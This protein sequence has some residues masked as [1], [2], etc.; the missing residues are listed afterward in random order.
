M[1]KIIRLRTKT[2]IKLSHEDD[3]TIDFI[4]ST[5]AK[6][7]DGD[8]IDPKGWILTNFLKNPVVLFGHDNR[9]LP[10]GKAENIR[11]E[12]GALKASVKFA[13]AEMNPLA[14]SVFQMVKGGFLNATS[15]G[16]SPV[17]FE[18]NDGGIKFIKQELLEFS[19]VP[20]PSNPEAL[21]TAKGLDL[22]PVKDWFKGYLDDWEKTKDCA[23]VS[24]SQMNNACD[25]IRKAINT[26]KK[27]TITF[28][29]A[30]PDGTPIAPE[31]EAWDG[32]A[33][34][35]AA[36]VDD[37]KIMATFVEQTDEELKK[38]DFKLPHH[39]EKGS[40]AVVFRGV[41]AAM[42]ALLGSSGGVDI[43]DSDRR[44]VYNHLAKHYREFDKEPPEFKAVEDQTLKDSALMLDGDGKIKNVLELLTGQLKSSL[45]ETAELRKAVTEQ[46]AQIEELT[47]DIT[48]NRL[49]HGEKLIR[50]IPDKATA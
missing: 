2:E 41:V 17:E 15:V 10:V 33:Q 1:P 44:G 31:G 28:D 14:E 8:T 7:R 25:I 21:V 9:S 24:K 6:D 26:E 27:D 37:L 18:R 48:R 35:A 45:K 16:F 50:I 46:S 19:I 20:I 43:P 40:H 23:I 42:G 38:G 47:S 34:V 29:E 32:P 22:S 13:D 11:L 4:I 12:G 5:A 36:D 49:P 39:R 3:R 30:H